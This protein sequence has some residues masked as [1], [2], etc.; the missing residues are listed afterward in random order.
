ME[1]WIEEPFCSLDFETTGP[2][3]KT[4]R[5]VEC[6]LLIVDNTGT[7]IKEFS[8]LVNPEV[9]I[10]PEATAVH[11]IDNNKVQSGMKTKDLINCLNKILYETDLPLVIFNVP[12]DWCVLMEEIKRTTTLPGIVRPNFIDP[13]CMDKWLNKYRKGGRS[14]S[15]LAKSYQVRVEKSHSAKDDALVA[16]KIAR[17]MVKDLKEC[18]L[19]ELQEKQIKEYEGWKN[20][21]NSYWKANK[22]DR[23]V[24]NGWPL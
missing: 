16:A 7:T 21:I 22:I 9:G 6:G 23:E 24:K 14:L 12:Y 11:G 20:H 1:K 2:D 8:T 4:A 3:P 15:T 10:P 13:L 5:V 17:K 19:E 18:S